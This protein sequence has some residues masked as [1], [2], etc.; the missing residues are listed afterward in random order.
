MIASVSALM[1]PHVLCRYHAQLLKRGRARVRIKRGRLETEA[2]GMGYFFSTS[3]LKPS[4]HPA[5]LHF[6]S[7]HNENVFSCSRVGADF[8]KPCHGTVAILA[9]GTSWVDAATQAF[10]PGFESHRLRRV[11][12]VVNSRRRFARRFISGAPSVGRLSSLSRPW[13]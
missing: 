9:Q 1:F 4:A 3:T 6:A 10:L 5:I 13:P 7:H 12:S 11:R 2:L 8:Q